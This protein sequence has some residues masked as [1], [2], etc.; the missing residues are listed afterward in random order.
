[1]AESK[2]GIVFTKHDLG[3]CEYKGTKENNIV[4]SD[5]AISWHGETS[6]AT[7]ITK[8]IEVSGDDL[9]INFAS[10][11]IGGL[12]I[13]LHITLSDCDLYSFVFE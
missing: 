13:K 6:G 3:L 4:F 9:Y 5:H 1:M 10:S 12:K 8:P 2:D 11:A 7:V